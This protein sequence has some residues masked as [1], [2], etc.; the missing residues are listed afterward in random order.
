[1][2]EKKAPMRQGEAHFQEEI[3]RIMNS[4]KTGKKKKGRRKR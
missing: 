4:C 3:K 2:K 1:M